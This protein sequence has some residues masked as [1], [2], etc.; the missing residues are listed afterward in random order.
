MKR[1]SYS[2]GWTSAIECYVNR[3]AEL[4]ELSVDLPHGSVTFAMDA[5]ILTPFELCPR[6]F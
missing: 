1:R 2:I 3:E 6:E 5:S 4:L